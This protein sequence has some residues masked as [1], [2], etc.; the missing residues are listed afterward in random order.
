M[1]SN[2]SCA[3]SSTSSRRGL[4]RGLAYWAGLAVN[5]TAS[6][7]GKE[8]RRKHDLLIITGKALARLPHLRLDQL[9][10]WAGTVSALAEEAE[11]DLAPATMVWK[12]GER[13]LFLLWTGS[14]GRGKIRTRFVLVRIKA[15]EPLAP[16]APS[17][18][19]TSLRWD[20]GTNKASGYLGLP[21]WVQQD[22]AWGSIQ[23]EQSLPLAP[24]AP[25]E[26]PKEVRTRLGL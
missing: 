10:E 26:R 8:V 13:E 18:F 19:R 23:D 1:N 15:L 14:W 4:S 17:S 12:N 20:T 9:E 22:S 5:T 7:D 11:G 2:N 25:V 24:D 16:G 3:G 21:D 6:D